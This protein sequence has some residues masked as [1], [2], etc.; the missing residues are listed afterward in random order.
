MTLADISCAA[1]I[2]MLQVAKVELAKYENINK[3]MGNVKAA[4][5]NFGEINDKPMADFGQWFD[6]ALKKKEE[7]KQAAE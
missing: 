1:S 5:P 2:T 3:W 7:S 4:V 6:N